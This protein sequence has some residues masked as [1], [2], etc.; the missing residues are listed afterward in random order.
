MPDVKWEETVVSIPEGGN[1]QVCFTSDI[2][3]SQPYQVRVGV[4]GKGA[5]PATQ[6]R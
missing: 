5:S 6:G 3:T 2:G 4:R 1:R